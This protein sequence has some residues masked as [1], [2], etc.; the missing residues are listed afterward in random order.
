MKKFALMMISILLGLTVLSG[1]AMLAPGGDLGGPEGPGDQTD[2]KTPLE[3]IQEKYEKLGEAATIVQTIDITQDGEVQYESDKTYTKAGSG[4]RVTGTVKQL[5]L[6]S[7][8]PY[9]ETAIE[10]TLKAGEFTPQLELDELYFT[11]SK[12][13]NGTLE[14]TVMDSSVETVLGLK[15][16]L[17]AAVHGL[18]LTI[19]TDAAHV[20]DMGIRYASGESEIVIKLTFT[21]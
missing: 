5:N 20:T 19:V 6:L 18:V 10:T 21:Y 7:S 3:L 2:E 12:V 8:G 17:P 4:Y 1:C 15:E 11:N 14:A 9:T 13:E 16:D